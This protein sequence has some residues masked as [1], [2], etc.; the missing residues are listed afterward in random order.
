LVRKDRLSGGSSLWTANPSGAFMIVGKVNSD[1]EALLRLT[2]RDANGTDLEI[3][4][5]VGSGMEESSRSIKSKNR[6]RFHAS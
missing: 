2:L 5:V 6:S 1:L 3:E 4:A